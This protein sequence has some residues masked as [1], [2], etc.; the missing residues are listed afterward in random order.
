MKSSVDFNT[1]KVTDLSLLQSAW[2]CLYTDWLHV[3]NL[4]AI[5]IMDYNVSSVSASFVE[6]LLKLDILLP[7]HSRKLSM[8]GLYN[9]VLHTFLFFF[10]FST[11]ATV[12][13]IYSRLL[14]HG[15]LS[16]TFA[17]NDYDYLN[18]YHWLTFSFACTV[19][20]FV[21]KRQNLDVF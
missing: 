19:T 9:M 1:H 13:P 17:G 6:V 18:R 8:A 14:K 5:I 2:I 3:P 4:D 7:V 11:F 10:S 21:R 16:L 20:L 12:L 15:L